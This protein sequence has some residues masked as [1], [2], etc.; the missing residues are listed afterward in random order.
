MKKWTASSN[1]YPY[2]PLILPKRNRCSI[3]VKFSHIQSNYGHTPTC[4]IT[5]I[6]YYF[7]SY[8][9]NNAIPPVG[10]LMPENILI[11]V[12]LPAPLGPII[13]KISP[14]LTPKVNY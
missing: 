5:S 9:F 10:V 8:S 14:L 11:K 3:G 6:I 7:G 1:S 4:Y 12:D 13:P 2:N